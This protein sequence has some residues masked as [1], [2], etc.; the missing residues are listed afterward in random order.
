MQE[1]DFSWQRALQGAIHESEPNTVESKIGF[2]RLAI[3]ERFVSPASI[4]RKEEDALFEALDALRALDWQ[5]LSQRE[6]LIS[7]GSLPYP[8]HH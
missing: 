2:A 3:L 5:R 8:L 4:D 6:E 1:F 7:S